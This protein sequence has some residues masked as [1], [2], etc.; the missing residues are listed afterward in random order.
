MPRLKNARKVSS[1]SWNSELLNR[2]AQY[3][4]KRHALLSA[5]AA[6]FRSR[7]YANVS[8]SDLAEILH[9]TKPT[10]YHYIPSKEEILF[11]CVQ[12]GL[13]GLEEALTQA[14]DRSQPALERLRTLFRRHVQF[15]TEDFG[16]CL[17]LYADDVQSPENRAVLK[18]GR[19]RLEKGLQ[20]I[21]LEGIADGS[22]AP[23]DPKFVFLAVFAALNT[24]PRWYRPDGELNPEEI[25]DRLLAIMFDGLRPRCES[26]R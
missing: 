4:L 8:M 14:R 26:P 10:L 20:E 24:V 6:A 5:A 1:E 2:E 16:A 3:R 19:T 11:E 13:V 9:V 12:Q 7:G 18:E 23:C 17:V 25:A 21:I 15:A 22:I